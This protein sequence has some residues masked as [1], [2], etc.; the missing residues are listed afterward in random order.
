MRWSSEQLPTPHEPDIPE[1]RTLGPQFDEKLHGRHAAVLMK[2]LTDQSASASKNIALTG[3][4]G[5]G[6]SSVILGVQGG[7]DATN[8]KWL[9]L[10]LSS[11]GVDEAQRGRVGDD[12][13]LAPLTNFIQ[14][15]IVKQLLY[16]KAPRDMPGSRYFRI[17]AFRAGR[18]MLWALAVA[19]GVFTVAVLLGLVARVKQVS[20]EW[21]SDGS[22]WGPWLVVG[23]LSALLGG[24]CFMALRGLQNPVKVDSVSAGGAAVSLSAKENSY[25]D[26]Y[27]DEIV[28]FFQRTNTQV[29]IFEDLDRFKDPH[30]FETLRELNTVLNNSEQIRSRPVKFVYAVRDSIFEQLEGGLGR[31]VQSERTAS[32]EPRGAVRPLAT[33]EASSS[34]I[35][36]A[37]AQESVPSANRTKFFDLVVPVVPFLTHRSARDLLA[38]EFKNSPLKPSSNVINLVGGHRALTDMRLIRN[39]RNEFEIY[40]A[41]VLSD[42]GLQGLTADRLFAMMVYK[43]THLEDFEAIRLGTSQIDAAHRAF[44]QMVEYQATYQDRKS[45]LALYRIRSGASWDRRAKAAGEHLQRT[46]PIV[47]MANANRV[48]AEPQVIT[49]DEA[50]DL[51]GLTSGNLWKKWFSTRDSVQIGAVGYAT[52]TLTFEQLQLLAGEAGLAMKNF[53]EADVSE[54]RRQSQQA[55]DTKL[56]VSTATMAQVMGRTDLTMPDDGGDERSLDDI[57]SNLVS[58]LARDLLAQGLLDE[59]YTLYCSDYQGVAISVS[60]MNFILHCVQ[61]DKADPLFRFDTPASI[62]AVETEVGDRFLGGESVFNVS[63]FDHYLEKGSAVLTGAFDRLAVRAAAG[64]TSF[65]DLYLGDETFDAA[66]TK[67]RFAQEISPRWPGVFVHLAESVSPEKR[68][69]LIDQA[70]RAASNQMVYRTSEDLV[71]FIQENYAEMDA[72]VG[73]LGEEQA[74]ELA[75]LVGQIEVS[76]DDLTKLGDAQCRTVVAAGHYLVTRANLLA[77]LGGGT[78]EAGVAAEHPSLALDAVKARNEVVYSHVVANLGSY[79]TALDDCEATVEDGGA[80]LEVLRDLADAPMRLVSS[81]V[82]HAADACRVTDLGDLGEAQWSLVVSAKKVPAFGIKRRPIC[83]CSRCHGSDGAV[84]GRSRARKYRRHRERGETGACI[85][86]RRNGESPAERPIANIGPAQVGGVP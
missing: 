14:K 34:A 40:Q 85:C 70:I 4:Y 37:S 22:A 63:V 81:V 80:F 42:K 20:P 75:S 86:S 24:V 10:S 57:V 30:I 17:D 51:A 55:L 53:V 41:S 12:G 60:A 82:E 78:S 65:I 44:R 83:G 38:E 64:D 47:H 61:V 49:S 77:A 79:L 9:N 19:L 58:P 71:R 76:V 66:N 15:E 59:N 16:R 56:F 11:L 2:V 35:M 6:K 5:S 23:L 45:R 25:F 29:A 67:R 73:D 7:L 3:H 46:L 84:P 27:L 72:F 8:V 39:T 26:E 68:V 28:Y 13:A 1:L 74:V 43:N 69:E 18:A 54:L 62:D 33:S 52:T 50:V 48:M 21:I 36:R 32:G 31:I